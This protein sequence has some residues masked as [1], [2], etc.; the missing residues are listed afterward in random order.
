MVKGFFHFKLQDY[1]TWHK[2]FVQ[3]MAMRK[4]FGAETE[5]LHRSVDNPNEVV[6]V[7]EFAT[8]DKAHAFMQSTELRAAMQNGGVIPPPIIVIT[9]VV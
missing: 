5:M 6:V 9:E 3:N 7:L 1:E 8:A 4:S 2:V